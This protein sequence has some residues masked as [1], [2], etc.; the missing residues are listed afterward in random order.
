[1]NMTKTPP[2]SMEAA[3]RRAA[4]DLRSAAE[5]GTTVDPR[6]ALELAA[7]LEAFLAGIEKDLEATP[8][9][10]ATSGRAKRDVP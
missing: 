10:I 4:N 3:L 8:D 6:Q 9:I 1:M 2:P 5:A 7:R